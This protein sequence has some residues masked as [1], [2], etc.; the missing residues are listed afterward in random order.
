[1][2]ER[3]GRGREGGCFTTSQLLLDQLAASSFRSGRFSTQNCLS[4]GRRRLRCWICW[5]RLR[6]D[7]GGLSGLGMWGLGEE[8]WQRDGRYLSQPSAVIFTLT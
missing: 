5:L 8:V 3:E 1:V 4:Q 2:P 7:E 6:T